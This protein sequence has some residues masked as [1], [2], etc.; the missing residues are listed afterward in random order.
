MA[1]M[2]IEQIKKTENFIENKK[3]LF[4]KYI[5]IA[6]IAGF[7]IIAIILICI[8]H[9]DNKKRAYE[10]QN[11]YFDASN[12][13]F[14]VCDN[15]YIYKFIADYYKAR[16]MLNFPKIFSAYGRD[17]YKERQ[18][19][20]NGTIKRIE[21]SVRYEKTF[22]RSFNDIKVYIEKGYRENETI[23][24]V[25]YDMMMGFSDGAAPMIALFYLVKDGDSFVIKDKFD[26][27]TSKYIVACTETEFVKNLYN[28]TKNRLE[29]ALTGN[30]NLKIA[31][32][33]L[34]QYEMNMGGE[35][36][37]ANNKLVENL[38][39]D[40]LDPIEDSDYIYNYIIN[41]KNEEEAKEKLDKYLSKVIA[42]YNKA[43]P[44]EVK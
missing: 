38:G 34:R 4:M 41:K 14:R 18:E 1:M 3:N 31:Y 17:Y 9:E 21:E 24:V 23:C 22:V 28:D 6:M 8:I 37:Y 25:T 32:N 13:N 16:T 7:A 19:D 39:I 11:I 30:E 2:E 43:T 35:L 44:N 29:R 20:K 40:K 42:S 15:N 5:K 33:S 36:N 27:G 10:S 26:V 12:I